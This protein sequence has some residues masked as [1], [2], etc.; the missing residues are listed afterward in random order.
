M[1]SLPQ[2]TDGYTT[3]PLATLWLGPIL[4]PVER[5]CLQS[6]LEMDWDITLYTYEDVKNLPEGLIVKDA[7]EIATRAEIEGSSGVPVQDIRLISDI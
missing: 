4:H 7:N 2:K 5:I 1:S 6:M 3:P